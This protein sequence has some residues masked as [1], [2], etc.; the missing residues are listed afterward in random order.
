[1]LCAVKFAS[2]WRYTASEALAASKAIHDIQK[3]DPLMIVLEPAGAAALAAGNI[4]EA[5]A[6]YREFAAK[7]PKETLARVRLSRALLVAG[8]GELSREEDGRRLNWNRIPQSRTAAWLGYCNMT[9][10]ASIQEG[11]HLQGAEAELRKAHEL[12]PEDTDC[13]ADLAILREHDTTG[14][15]YTSKSRLNEAIAT[16]HEMEKI[17]KDAARPYVDSILFDLIFSR[18]FNEAT[19]MLAELPQTQQRLSL[20][21]A[22]IAAVDGSATAIQRSLEIAR[23]SNDRKPAL[24]VAATI[25][26]ICIYTRLLQIFRRLRPKGSECRTEALEEVQG[27]RN[28]KPFNSVIKADDPRSAIQR[29]FVFLID[30][31]AIDLDPVQEFGYIVSGLTRRKAKFLSRQGG[32]FALLLKAAPCL[33]PLPPTLSCQTFKWALREMTRAAIAF[34]YKALL[35]NREQ[36][37][38]HEWTASTGLWIRR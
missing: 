29:L 23:D 34:A 16:Y 27:F 26:G 9:Y 31:T 12:D 37:L 10:R 30:P 19:A 24:K 22:S 35:L 7:Y 15:R 17:N 6:A 3:A 18:Q 8:L 25:L 36:L 11:I 28:T 13:L 38:L 5:L 32:A 1:M 4:R 20:A 2:C 21:L 14:E 33:A